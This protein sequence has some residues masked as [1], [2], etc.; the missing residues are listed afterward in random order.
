VLLLDIEGTTTPITF[1]HDV[2]FP[3][4]RTRL[5]DF[6]AVHRGQP[7]VLDAIARLRA[8]HTA[9]ARAGVGVPDW[10]DSDDRGL[11][12][13]LEFLMDRD[14]KSPGLK[15]LQGLIWDEGYRRGDLHGVVF[16]T[17]VPA[18]RRCR[19]A[20]KRIAIYSSGSVLA[21][22]LLFSTTPDGD[23]TTMIDGFFDTGVGAKVEPASYSRI[24]S[25][26]GVAP[27]EIL[28]LTDA[29][30]EVTAARAAGVQ[31]VIV[32]SPSVFETISGV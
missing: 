2:L 26:L 28:F 6:I 25:L 15:V 17:V 8:E 21:Q 14:R 1:V 32:T 4:A 23:L 29:T 22:R 16:D 18:M 19:A 20:G 31:A 27:G 5:P 30:A 3:Y 7:D 10:P 13:Y 24:A 9:D 11:V 12:R